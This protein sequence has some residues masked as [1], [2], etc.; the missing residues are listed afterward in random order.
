MIFGTPR[1]AGAGPAEKAFVQ[2]GGPDVAG[3]LAELVAGLH[4]QRA[5]V[6][7]QGGP[8]PP[9]LGQQR[10]PGRLAGPGC[11]TGPAA[12]QRPHRHMRHEPPHRLPRPSSRRHPGYARKDLGKF[13]PPWGPFPAKIRAASRGECEWPWPVRCCERQAVPNG[14]NGLDRVGRR[15]GCGTEASFAGWRPPRPEVAGA[16]R[17]GPVAGTLPPSTGPRALHPGR[18]S[19]RRGGCQ[20]L[21]R[22]AFA[23]LPDR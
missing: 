23:Y 22:S 19:P 21:L 9:V 2:V 11:A 18:G 16:T 15:R 5:Q 4:H 10:E 12:P 6:D 1:R 14:I 20:R 3:E 8:L 13:R 17:A 7:K